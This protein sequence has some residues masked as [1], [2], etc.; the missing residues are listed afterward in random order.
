MTDRVRSSAAHLARAGFADPV[1]ASAAL[2]AL[3]EH[4]HAIEDDPGWGALAEDLGAAADPDQALRLLEELP[5]PVRE[6]L[7]D[8]PVRRAAFAIVAGASE[9]LGAHLVRHP[10]QLG[11]LE[12]TATPAGAARIRA[13]LLRAVGADPDAGVPVARGGSAAELDSLRVAYRRWL[14]QIAVRDLV[15]HVPMDQVSAELADLADA[16]LECGLAIAR[17][18]LPADAA[19]CRLSVIA[20]GKCGARELNYVSDVDVIFVAEAVDGV[21]ESAALR[22]ATRLAT[23]LIRACGEATAEGSLWQVDAALRPEGKAGALVRTLASHLGYYE[24]WATTWEFQALLKAR[25]A[26]GDADLGRAYADAIAP[27]V[28]QAANRPDFVVDVQRM[29]QRVEDHVPAHQAA[30]QLKLGRGGLRDVEFAVQLL[31]LVH[32]RSDVMV[33]SPTTLVA[34]E[35]LATWGYVGREDGSTLAAAYRFLRT[36]EHRIQLQHLTRTHLVPEAEAEVRRLGRS[37]GLRRDPVAELTE[38]WARHA[39]EVRRIHEKLF[40]RP[41]LQAVARLDPGAARLTPEAA[42]ERLQALGYTDPAGALRHLEALTSGVSRR[43]AIQR[44]LLPVL[45]GWFADGP[46]PDAALLG[47]RRMSDDLGSTP[48]YLRL[49]RDESLAAERMA[50]LLSSS[51]YASDLLLRS[52][53]AVALLAHDDEL[54]PRSLDSLA[55]EARA[56]VARHEE[57]QA[58]VT[59]VRAMRRRELFRLAAAD[60]LGTADAPQ[61]MQGISDVTTATLQAAVD[62]ATQEVSRAQGGMP[63]RFAVIAMGRFGGEEVGFGSDAD[64]MFVHDPLPGAEEK[65]SGDAALAIANEVRR[66]LSVPSPDPPLEIDADLRPEGRQGP[67]VRSLASYAAYYERWS[68]PWEAQALL[69]ARP[70]CGD[71]EVGERFAALID[72]LRWPAQGLSDEALTQMRRLKARMESERLPRGA[73]PTLHTKLGRGGLSDV[74]WVAQLLQLRHAA[75]VPSLRVTS[76]LG[77]LAAARDADLLSE[78]DDEELVAAWL[79]ATRVRNAVVLSRGRAG[80][81]VPSGPPDLAGVAALLGY[82]PGRSSDLLE[83]YRRVTRRARAVV[84]R[85]FYG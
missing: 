39:R 37:L 7:I 79:M 49:L 53:D 70:V 34:L 38:E 61:V 22:T 46:D 63:T 48:W 29:R 67:L 77:A 18:E 50:R 23:G 69:R 21:D 83:D 80:D 15:H 14:V 52:P 51:R 42:A 1:R 32:G 43:A 27:L 68:S 76:T 3:A 75:Q 45:L 2:E 4:R 78:S 56:A 33:R 17:S 82:R 28:W 55:H 11:A 36:L 74:E 26:A 24:R 19:P 59:A 20:M 44:T 57:A 62:A 84:E 13:D 41:L 85:L 54:R 65:Q 73:D 60:I 30:R 81:M 6:E 31:Q 9:A 72:P 64:V 16:A 10:E 25:P 35:A 66:L 40:Y 12:A 5:A 58:G 71:P 47:F 8:H